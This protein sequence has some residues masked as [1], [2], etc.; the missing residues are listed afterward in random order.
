MSITS[1]YFF[2]IREY[3]RRRQSNFDEC[4]EPEV[5]CGVPFRGSKSDSGVKCY[6]SMI[7]EF[8]ITSYKV[9]NVMIC[10][11]MYNGVCYNS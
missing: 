3:Y 11:I 9:F 4:I 7:R 1:R 2:Y 6:I 8:Y 5:L 10:E